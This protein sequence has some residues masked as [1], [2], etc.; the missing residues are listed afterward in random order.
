MLK[1]RGE[2]FA[3]EDGLEIATK[4]KEKYSYVCNDVQKEY[5]KYDTKE[6]D[7]S[8]KFIQSTKFRK[9]VHKTM[10]NNMVEIDVGYERFLAPE[11]FFHPVSKFYNIFLG[12]CSLRLVQTN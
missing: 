4:I 3:P 6:K 1:D 8:G 12:I 11:M 5:A 9:F 7:S 10:N 2:N